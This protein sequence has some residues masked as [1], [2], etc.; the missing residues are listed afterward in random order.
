MTYR[1]KLTQEK[2]EMITD[3]SAGGCQGCPCDFGYEVP[4]GFSHCVTTTCTKCWDREIEAE[5]VDGT[6]ETISVER[7]C[8]GDVNE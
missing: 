7:L 8:K 5:C 4:K 1:E 6:E 3:K 2:P